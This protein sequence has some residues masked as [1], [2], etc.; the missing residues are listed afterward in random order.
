MNENPLLDCKPYPKFDLIKP[1]HILPALQSVLAQSREVIAQL[2][3]GEQQPTWDNFVEPLEAIDD[4]LEQLWSPVSHLNSIQDSEALRNVVQ[5]ALPILSDYSAE[6]GQNQS[7]YSRFETLAGSAQFKTLSVTQKAVIEH[8]LRDFKLSGIA[9]SDKDQAKYKKL[10]SALSKIC[11]QYSQ[12]ILDAT[13][14]WS[15]NIEDKQDLAGLPGSAVDAA[16]NLAKKSEQ[17]GWS[18]NLQAPSFIPF[19]TYAQNRELRKQMYTAY[20]TRASDQGPNAGEYDNSE[21][22]QKIVKK[23]QQLA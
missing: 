6:V 10:S 1:E 20:V 12:N 4:K 15:L 7:L 5:E 21:L 8:S 9:L 13:Q 3:E 14:A 23:R 17:K 19:M 18:F 22:M 2:G 11:N 16:K